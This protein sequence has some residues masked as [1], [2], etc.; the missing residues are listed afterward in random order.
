MP[1][2]EKFVVGD[3]VKWVSQSQGYWKVKEGVVDAVVPAHR[4]F[5]LP[6]DLKRYGT[7]SRD[8]ES[9]VVRVGGKLYW[10]VVSLLKR[11]SGET[12][13]Q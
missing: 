11:E 4:A 8:H 1:E 6:A 12:H 13:D 7:R 9:Y 2:R 5:S 3:R 10:P